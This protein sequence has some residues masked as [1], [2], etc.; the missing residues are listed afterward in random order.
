KPTYLRVKIGR[1]LQRIGAVALK[2]AVYALP[3]TDQAREDFAWVYREILDG[4]GEA[5]ECEARFFEG[6]SDDQIEGLFHAARNADY[7]ALADDARVVQ[8]ALPRRGE[9]RNERRAEL[10]ADVARLQKRLS[11][12]AAMD[13][14]GTSGREAAAGLI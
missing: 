7:E 10:E 13:F 3:A 9:L 4:G 8:K 5:F 6:L 14:F 1:H 11:E 2:N 12:I